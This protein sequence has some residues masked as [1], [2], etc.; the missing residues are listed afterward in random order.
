PLPLAEAP[1]DPTHHL[2]GGQ[3][4][5]VDGQ[6][7]APV[8]ALA[9][10]E[11]PRHLLAAPSGEHGAAAAAVRPLVG[12]VELGGEPHHGAEGAQALHDTGPT[13]KP[14]ARRHDVPALVGQLVED[15]GLALAEVRLAVLPED[16]RDRLALPRDDHGVG[17]DEA[18]PQPARQESAHRRFP[19]AHEADE[20][21]ALP[22]L[23]VAMIAP[24]GLLDAVR[25][26]AVLSGPPCVHEP[27]RAGGHAAPSTLPRAPGAR[28]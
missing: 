28:P 19:G 25:R 12:G 16:L 10:I 14:A 4:S 26:S 21:H 23:H 1:D 9:Y 27:A 7:G 18:E 2:V 24:L 6:V 13:R 5:R 22:A 11:E 8:V 17:L 3:V 20:E 15:V